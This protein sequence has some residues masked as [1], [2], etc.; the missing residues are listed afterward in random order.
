MKPETIEKILF[1]QGSFKS[2]FPPS[3]RSLNDRTKSNEFIKRQ[4]IACQ[5]NKD[6]CTDDFNLFLNNFC[7]WVYYEEDEEDEVDEED[8]EDE[9]DIELVE[10]DKD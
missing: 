7:T 3:S 1:L 5:L 10:L 9:E 2:E 4:S 8:E 6:G